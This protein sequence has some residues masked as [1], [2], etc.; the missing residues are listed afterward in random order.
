MR[1]GIC[2]KELLLSPYRLMVAVPR[3]KDFPIIV[4]YCREMKQ[5]EY[6]F[7]PIDFERLLGRK[8]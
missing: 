4:N 7:E 8:P 6:A 1:R 5:L 3:V 2:T